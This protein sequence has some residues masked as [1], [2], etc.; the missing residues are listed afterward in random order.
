M[1]LALPPCADDDPPEWLRVKD[2]PVSELAV[3]GGMLASSSSAH[4]SELALPPLDEMSWRPAVD[5]ALLQEEK[6]SSSK[7]SSYCKRLRIGGEAAAI[8]M[9]SVPT[10]CKIQI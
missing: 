9:E 5:P 10:S 6:M 4:G 1:R 7:V 8:Q 2:E 3:V